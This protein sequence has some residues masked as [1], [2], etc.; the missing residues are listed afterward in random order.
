MVDTRVNSISEVVQHNDTGRDQNND[1][2][3]YTYV[4]PPVSLPSSAPPQQEP[5]G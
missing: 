4:C 1:L 2:L 3:S 5:D